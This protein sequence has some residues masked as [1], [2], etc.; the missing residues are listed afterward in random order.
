MQEKQTCK[1]I[2]DAT[3]SAHGNWQEEDDVV[4]P[5]RVYLTT[6]PYL[7]SGCI[8]QGTVRL[9]STG[10]GHSVCERSVCT[11]S[12]TSI[13]VMSHFDIHHEC[14]REPIVFSAWQDDIIIDLDVTLGFRLFLFCLK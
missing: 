10:G 7:Y 2:I 8:V 1:V 11:L 13:E 14:A 6:M 12:G 9:R 3:Q 4:R 5:I